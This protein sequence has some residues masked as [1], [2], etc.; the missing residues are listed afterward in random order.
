MRSSR[1]S[2]DGSGQWLFGV[3]AWTLCAMYPWSVSLAQSTQCTGMDLTCLQEDDDPHAGSCRNVS[4]KRITLAGRD[5]ANMRIGWYKYSHR[6]GGL[7]PLEHATW[8]LVIDDADF[9]FFVERFEL[10]RYIEEPID[11]VSSCLL[12]D[13]R[14][15]ET[16]RFEDAEVCLA[17]QYLARIADECAVTLTKGILSDDSP[18]QWYGESVGVKGAVPLIG[19]STPTYS[20][21]LSTAYRRYGPLGALDVLEWLE[22]ADTVGLTQVN[23]CALRSAFECYSEGE[24]AGDV[25]ACTAPLVDGDGVNAAPLRQ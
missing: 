1:R 16:M 9:Q 10:L 3:L 12:G 2:I 4:L 23:I 20:G 17:E 6:G 15:C 11:E 5:P 7:R 13:F 18:A 24:L 25:S 14:V 19:P 22:L 8:N 21:N